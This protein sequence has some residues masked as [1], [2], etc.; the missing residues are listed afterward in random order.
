M[1]STRSTL[2]AIAASLV[3]SPVAQAATGN[4]D[5]VYGIISSNPTSGVYSAAADISANLLSETP[6]VPTISVTETAAQTA[7]IALA[8]YSGQAKTTLG[9]NHAYAQ[10]NGFNNG[11]FG[12][13]SFSGWYDQVT[14]TGGTGTGTVQFSVQLTGVASVGEFAGGAAYGLFASDLHP[15]QLI[16]TVNIVDTVLAPTAPWALDAPIGYSD[17]PEVTTITSYAI[18]ASNY[19]DPSIMFTTTPPEL[20]LTGPGEVGIPSNDPPQAYV[21]LVLT[22]GA[23]QAVNVTLSGSL[24]FTY[25]EAFYL[26]GALETGIYDGLGAFAVFGNP[27]P[28]PDG[29]GPT[30]LDFFNSA[31]LNTVVL[32]QGA[33]FAS[34]S[35]AAYNVTAV[36]EPGE[37]VL[38]L[39][40]LGLIGWRAR[41]RA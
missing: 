26:I 29:T 31:H 20:Q 35:G 8:N 36:P 16:D 34:A 22:P 17:L 19:N 10:S 15:T 30:T 14:I 32:P 13:N 28:T 1:N 41:R 23:D 27:S 39:A 7:A 38:M 5:D 11:A 18:G 2:F 6:F 37:W 25:G 12:V 3:A 40:G 21:N 4:V 33:S 24:T 9:N